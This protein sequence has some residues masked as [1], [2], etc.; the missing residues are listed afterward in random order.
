MATKKRK[1]K[2]LSVAAS[3]KK[4]DLYDRIV[5]SVWVLCAFIMAVVFV[6]SMSGAMAG[7]LYQTVTPFDR[8][9]AIGSNYNRDFPINT[10]VEQATFQRTGTGVV[11]AEITI[12]IANLLSYQL[13]NAHPLTGIVASSTGPYADELVGIDSYGCSHKVKSDT[14]YSNKIRVI[15]QATSASPIIPSAGDIALARFYYVPGEPIFN[16]R[17]VCGDGVIAFNEMCDDG[18]LNGTPGHCTSSCQLP[19]G[20]TVCPQNFSLSDQRTTCVSN[21]SNTGELG[22]NTQCTNTMIQYP[23]ANYR[24]YQSSDKRYRCIGNTLNA[25]S[26]T[27]TI[28]PKTVPTK[29]RPA[30]TQ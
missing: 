26:T 15:C 16:P 6:T 7:V 25:T 29:T 17:G 1:T 28:P 8:Q 10:G 2:S 14:L 24:C 22:C 13:F 23:A 5:S 19:Y 18:D 11:S 21:W 20:S 3:M 27:S 30:I 4:L 9:F 12:P